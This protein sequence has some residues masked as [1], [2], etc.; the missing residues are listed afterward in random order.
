MALSWTTVLSFL[1]LFGS[2]RSLHGPLLVPTGG[3]DRDREYLRS[4]GIDFDIF[5]L[6]WPVTADTLTF[7]VRYLWRAMLNML[8]RATRPTPVAR[9]LLPWLFKHWTFHCRLR[10]VQVEGFPV[11]ADQIP[12]LIAELSFVLAGA[13][14]KAAG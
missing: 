4:G 7:F 8:A 6:T 2:C 14:A 5:G 12:V 10:R 3:I 13:D 11:L 1:V 9:R